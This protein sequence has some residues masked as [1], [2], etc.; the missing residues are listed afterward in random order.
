MDANP[1]RPQVWPIMRP[2][3]VVAAALLSVAC[4]RSAPPSPPRESD[5][6]LLARADSAA[7]RLSTTLKERLV[8]APRAVPGEQVLQRQR[9]HDH[10]ALDGVEA[11]PD[12]RL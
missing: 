2:H 6:A 12:E 9:L 3:S 11:Q 8:A 1:A 5:E 7:V 4:Q 10:G